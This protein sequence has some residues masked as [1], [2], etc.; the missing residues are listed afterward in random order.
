MYDKFD[1]FNLTLYNA[2]N[3]GV[4]VQYG[5]TST[6]YNIFHVI[7]TGLPFVNCCYDAKLNM[8]TNKCYLSTYRLTTTNTT[9]IFQSSNNFITATFNKNQESCNITISY[10]H[11]LTGLDPAGNNDEPFPDMVFN[12][13]ITG[14]DKIDYKNSSNQRITF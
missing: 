3:Y 1:L 5:L 6:Q 8:N 10:E 2:T 7:M 12:F 14:V 9:Q 4:A 13:I 11:I